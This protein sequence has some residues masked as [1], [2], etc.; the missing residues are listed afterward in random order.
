MNEPNR[1]IGKWL[2]VSELH[3]REGAKTKQWALE[4]VDGTL[5]GEIAWHGPWRCYVVTP[6]Q[7]TIFHAQCLRD[8]AEFLTSVRKERVTKD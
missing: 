4:N 2:S 3:P 8:I 7:H 5:L 6:L 1:R